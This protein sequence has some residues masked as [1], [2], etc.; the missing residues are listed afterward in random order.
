MSI[1]WKKTI[2]SDSSQNFVSN[3]TPKLGDTITISLRIY[4]KTKVEKIFL[5]AWPHGEM[6]NYRMKKNK[7]NKNK[8]NDFFKYYSVKFKIDVEIFRYKFMLIVNGVEYFYT[9]FGLHTGDVPENFSFVIESNTDFS[10]WS[11]QSVFYQIFPDRFFRSGETKLSDKKCIIKLKNNKTYTLKRKLFKWD[12]NILE[13]NPYEAHTMQ[14]F[15]GTFQGIKEKIPYLQD[16]GVTSL[17]L[18]PI[19]ESRSNHRYDIDDYSKV[20]QLLGN[21]DNL[22]D[23]IKS[24]H[25]NKMTIIFDGVLNHTSLYHK[26]FD[27]LREHKIKGAYRNGDSKYTNY[28]YKEDNSLGYSTWMGSIILPKLKLSNREVREELLHKKNSAIKKWLKKPFNID[29]W[30]LDTANILGK[31]ESKHF[32]EQFSEELHT[33]IKEENSDAYIVGENFFDPVDLIGKNKYEG[34]MNYRG[35][36][37]PIAKWL[38]NEIYYREIPRK[39]GHSKIKF[40]AKDASKQIHRLLASIPFQHQLRMYNLLNSHDTP[41]FLTVIKKDYNKLKIGVTM[42]FTMIGIPSIYYGDEIGIEGGGDPDCRRPMIWNKKKQNLKIKNMYKKLINL[43]KEKKSLQYGSFLI[44]YNKNNILSYARFLDDEVIIVVCNGSNSKQKIDLP[45]I[46][47]GIKSA[48][49]IDFFKEEKVTI[50]KYK[51]PLELENYESIILI[52]KKL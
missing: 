29:G 47:L 39:H 7:I 11:P 24:L 5:L 16:L 13:D 17:Y 21:E 18:T 41:R 12:E 4:K 14:F 23:L 6:F 9:P 38:T 26:W 32:N 43:R 2:Y 22:V 8:K 25:K 35:F 20:D 3:A 40:K 46:R 27:H 49:F 42:L 37:S 15:G 48:Q 31:F 10:S 1:N 19:F 33:A 30:R 51:L 44:L 36:F 34:A 50:N 52:K 28:Y 45:L